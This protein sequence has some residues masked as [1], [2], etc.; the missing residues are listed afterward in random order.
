MTRGAL[1]SV[2]GSPRAGAGLHVRVD[3]ATVLVDAD[4]TLWNTDGVFAAAQL[5][6]LKD[7]RSQL[8]VETPEPAPLA[9]VR[10]VDQAI[11]ERHHDGLRYPPVLLVRGLEKALSGT[12]PDAAARASLRGRHAYRI[13][14]ADAEAIAV[15]FQ[16]ALAATPALRPGVREGLAAMHVDGT[17]LLVVSEA[18]KGRVEATATAHGI[19][20]FFE[21]VL[22]GRKSVALYRR[23]L[24]LTRAGRRVYMVGDQMNRD[25]EPASAAGLETIY[26]PGGF[27]PRWD[28]GDASVEPDHVITD[29]SEVVEIVGAHRG[30]AAA[31]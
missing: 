31:A 17:R 23:V 24:A 18:S 22:E 9:F 21:R 28:R 3:P 20:G 8:G 6:I 7:V 30:A 1:P 29:F 16:S 15:R 25:I 27:Q 11:A 5:G 2:L 10:E 14:A 4:N 13:S 26:F 19:L 12:A